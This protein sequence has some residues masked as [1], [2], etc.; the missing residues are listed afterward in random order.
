M[1]LRYITEYE[2]RDMYQK[3]AFTTYR[4]PQGSQLTP[5]AKQFLT[6]FRI[7]Q[8][9]PA[10]PASTNALNRP[11]LTKKLAP[12]LKTWVLRPDGQIVDVPK[13]KKHQ[14]A[15][16]ELRMEEFMLELL[17]LLHSDEMPSGVSA[18]V[19]SWFV[20]WKSANCGGCD[21]CENC[22]SENG[23]GESSY[24]A[25]DEPHSLLEAFSIDKTL[26]KLARSFYQMDIALRRIADQKMACPKQCA[27]Y[28]TEAEP[29]CNVVSWITTYRKELLRTLEKLHGNQ[30]ERGGETL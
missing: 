19:K 5:S 17:D 11:I 7:Q 23:N 22:N 2:L 27:F 14:C 15:G 16:L 26:W 3:Q 18:L 10:S 8:E 20:T 24:E 30:V 28:P 4:L 21:S 12:T 25:K 9:Q 6:D 29:N 1:T 13:K